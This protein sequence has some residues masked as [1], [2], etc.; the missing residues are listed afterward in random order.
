MSL[1][2]ETHISEPHCVVWKT[3]EHYLECRK[4]TT[5]ARASK[6]GDEID[7]P[8]ELSIIPPLQNTQTK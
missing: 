7:I 8:E 1:R 2:V 4:G 6:L 5:R 3:L